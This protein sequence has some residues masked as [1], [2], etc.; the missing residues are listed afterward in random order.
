MS[1]AT[2]CPACATLFR[3]TPQQLQA[4]QGQVRC[5]RCATVFDGFRHLTTLPAPAVTRESQAAVASETTLAPSERAS[6]VVAPPPLDPAVTAPA[7]T[8]AGEEKGRAD[9]SAC[10]LPAFG[11]APGLPSVP[12]VP[13]GFHFDVSAGAARTETTPPAAGKSLTSKPDMRVDSPLARTPA[14]SA[15]SLFLQQA[16]AGRRR[17]SRVW[18][19]GCLLLVITFGVQAAYFHRQDIAAH[20]PA[21][22]PALLQMCGVFNCEVPLPQRPRLI[23]IEAS[24][25]QSLDPL[26]P[27]LLQ[28]TATLRNHAEYD[29]AYPAL[30]LVLT[31]TREHTLARRIFLPSEYLDRGRNSEAGFPA[32]AEITVRLDLDTGELGAAG[33]R[34]DL[35]P[36]RP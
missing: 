19:F 32:K 7:G 9:A 8:S 26:R 30:D 34:L 36:A 23:N 20:Y 22:R 24:D 14:L 25:L 21:L 4:R 35:L 29:L 6:A 18:S 1:M 2:R 15:D 28:L 11:D 16:S 10:A 33:F 31:N 17:G 5:G 13:A 3:V 12:P 27:G